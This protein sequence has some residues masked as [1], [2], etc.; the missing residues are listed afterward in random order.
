MMDQ[1]S[2][3]LNPA[4]QMN[5]AS[6]SSFGYPNG[7]PSGTQ[8]QC[9]SPGP[10]QRFR[11][12]HQNEINMGQKQLNFQSSGQIYKPYSHPYANNWLNSHYRGGYGS[13]PGSRPGSVMST[14]STATVASNFSTMSGLSVIT[15]VTEMNNC[16]MANSQ[17]HT[18]SENQPIIP[19][20]IDA[21]ITN[22]NATLWNFTETLRNITASKNQKNLPDLQQCMPTV[23]AIHN[24]AKNHTLDYVGRRRVLTDMCC[25]LLNLLH[26]AH[27]VYHDD[28]AIRT[29]LETVQTLLHE[30]PREFP[31]PK[32]PPPPPAK[33]AFIKFMKENRQYGANFFVQFLVPN[34]DYTKYALKIVA[35][36]FVI[37]ETTI[38]KN[39]IEIPV[40]S[41]RQCLQNIKDIVVI[42]LRVIKHELQTHRE[43][44]LMCLNNIVMARHDLKIELCKHHGVEIVL[45]LLQKDTDEPLFFRVTLLLSSLLKPISDS[46]LGICQHFI[47]LGGVTVCAKLLDH[48][49]PRLL[50][51]LVECIKTVSDLP[52]TTT[53]PSWDWEN[54]Y[55]MLKVIGS[56]DYKL[57]SDIMGCLANLAG[58]N[59]YVKQYLVT[60]NAPS[61]LMRMLYSLENPK[62]ASWMPAE[63]D[64]FID[65][66][67]WALQVLVNKYKDPVP[68]CAPQACLAI[69]SS[70]DWNLRFAKVLAEG[71]AASVNRALLIISMIIRN[72]PE[73]L[74]TIEAT[75]YNNYPMSY[76]ILVRLNQAIELSVAP[77][78]AL[79]DQCRLHREPYSA[80][81]VEKQSFKNTVKLMIARAF[82]ATFL[83]IGCSENGEQACPYSNVEYERI[84]E[85][86]KNS[87]GAIFY[88]L[89]AL[90]MREAYD[91]VKNMLKLANHYLNNGK[92]EMAQILL[93]QQIH[94]DIMRCCAHSA[95][96][97]EAQSFVTAAT[98]ILK[99]QRLMY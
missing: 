5:S 75:T 26:Y 99:A 31:M 64:E 91:P 72:S 4:Y 68:N 30:H 63:R 54:L 55:R 25:L 94:D 79:W 74:L 69:V 15:D 22:L 92:Q 89:G 65:H 17:N 27:E 87:N 28:Q 70:K 29:I 49:S 81:A 1:T 50:R 82:R 13:A 62:F 39:E 76:Y 86:I 43:V 18:P 77:N 97:E 56:S 16:F 38:K 10:M 59:D 57:D 98:S 53:T 7:Y 47:K 9:A 44:A 21:I 78:A 12:N 24:Y 36:L 85:F 37:H 90:F 42:F 61:I 46:D 73:A 93:N 14:M 95:T 83:L 3:L 33:S 23:T 58:K 84:F 32:P 80:S 41:W 40:P 60:Y 35:A 2:N 67:L 45:E 19:S 71:L 20:D 52:E 51:A 8:S 11:N 88:W 48:G 96:Q 34:K 66:T 6:T